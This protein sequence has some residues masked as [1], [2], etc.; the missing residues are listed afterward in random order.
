[1]IIGD[2]ENNFYSCYF[3]NGL[4]HDVFID[5]KIGQDSLKK[6]LLSIF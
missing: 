6:M 4:E 3:E 5:R 1:M 2:N